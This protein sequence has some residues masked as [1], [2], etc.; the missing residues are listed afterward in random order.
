MKGYKE[1][2]SVLKE[3]QV[4][5]IN[6][7]ENKHREDI[8]LFKE[9]INSSATVDTIQIENMMKLLKERILY[10]NQHRKVIKYCCRRRLKALK[11]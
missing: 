9:K 2:V 3:E 11:L 4:K 5:E 7:L 10:W 6:L 8:I 1:K